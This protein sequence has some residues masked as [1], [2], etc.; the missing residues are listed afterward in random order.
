MQRIIVGFDGSRAAVA[1]LRW[2]VTEAGYHGAKV[3]AWTMFG[4]H[5]HLPHRGDDNETWVTRDRTALGETVHDETGGRAVYHWMHGRA[6]DELVQLSGDADLLV[7]GAQAHSAVTGVLLGSVNHV[8][9][10]GAHCP[11]AVVGAAQH[12]DWVER[13][14]VVGIDGTAPAR[15]AL[16]T[17][18]EEARVRGADLHVVHA[19]HWELAGYGLLA[20]TDRDL[21]S[22]GRRL[23]N[24]ELESADLDIPVRSFVLAGR[25]ADVLTT[26]SRRGS[27]L[28]VGSRTSGGLPARFGSVAAHCAAVSGCPVLVTRAQEG[29]HVT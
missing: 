18:A 27:L 28:V 9:L 29:S 20:P 23:V 15:V 14:V 7:L 19:V 13:P 2:A 10:H 3:E 16:A 24:A 22:W 4:Q 21:L 8:C 6:G 26:Y 1:A 12:L 5:A 17:A 11:V 25:P